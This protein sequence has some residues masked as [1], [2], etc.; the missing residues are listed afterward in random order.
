MF[1][2]TSLTSGG[3]FSNYHALP[4]YQ[5][6]AVETYFYRNPP[7]YPS[8]TYT[9]SPS[10]STANT[11]NT[12]NPSTTIGANGGVFNRYGRGFPDISAL[13]TFSLLTP[14][15]RS[16]YLLPPADTDIMGL[17]NNLPADNNG[18]GGTSASAPA[19][20]AMVALINDERLKA[21]KASVGFVNPALYANPGVLND[22]T[23]GVNY[24]CDLDPK[25]GF[26][27]VSG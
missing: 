22:I 27:A 16:Q 23:K 19:F 1:F 15:F 13:G 12:T 20:A 2:N 9:P 25:G 14:P 10:A 3:G 24:G 18:G 4:W 26:A 21:G 11:T 5:S 17:G 7:A 8:Y 6:S